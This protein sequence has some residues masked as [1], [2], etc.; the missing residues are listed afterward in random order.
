MYNNY[1][2]QREANARSVA[3]QDDIDRI[4]KEVN[5]GWWAEIFSA[6]ESLQ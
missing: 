2:Q 6:L 1:F 4:A 3:T 5:K